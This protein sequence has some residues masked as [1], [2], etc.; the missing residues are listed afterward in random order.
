[1]LERVLFYGME[2]DWMVSSKITE[3][4]EKAI[5]KQTE[6]VELQFNNDLPEYTGFSIVEYENRW[7]VVSEEYDIIDR[8]RNFVKSEENALDVL[9]M[10][11]ENY[12]REV[13][14]D[15][16]LTMS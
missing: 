14:T 11:G 3:A 15:R 5:Y 1:M 16:F 12:Q 4:E 2:K 13:K 9:K 6:L 7:Y 10:I 8:F